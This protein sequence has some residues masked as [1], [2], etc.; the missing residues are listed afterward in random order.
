MAQGVPISGQAAQIVVIGEDQILSLAADIQAAQEATAL[1]E[2]EEPEAVSVIKEA[3]EYSAIEED[4][5]VESG[6]EEDLTPTALGPHA[7]QVTNS[8]HLTTS[9]SVSGSA[10]YPHIID[11]AF[12]FSPITLA[13]ESS[14]SSTAT[15]SKS[16]TVATTPKPSGRASPVKKVRSSATSTAKVSVALSAIALVASIAL[17]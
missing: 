5:A 3:E 2:T 10:S 4:E 6:I 7:A 13:P 9:W 11:T 8:N 17:M 1:P 15:P 14:R 12:T 16:S